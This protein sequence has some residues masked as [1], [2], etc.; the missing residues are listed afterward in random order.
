MFSNKIED[1]RRECRWRWPFRRRGSRHE[2]AVVQ[3]FSLTTLH[4]MEKRIHVLLGCWIFSH[5]G[6]AV[7]SV[8]YEQSPAI[9]Y[10]PVIHLMF[11]LFLVGT[12]C[13]NRASAWLCLF[14][15]VAAIL[16]QG[17]FIW[18]RDAY[19]A[20]SIPVLAFDIMEFVSALLYLIFFFSSR[21][22]RYLAKPNVA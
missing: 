6:H 16:V 8:F 15:A 21:R 18:M 3:L 5:V 22:E 11:I 7:L 2:S 13:R 17:G 20:L 12:W 10:V 1:R 19:G 9:F 14:M 4:V